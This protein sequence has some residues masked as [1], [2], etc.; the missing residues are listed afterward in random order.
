MNVGWDGD[1]GSLWGHVLATVAS[2]GLLVMA[3]RRG[4]LDAAALAVQDVGVSIFQAAM[5][6]VLSYRFRGRWRWIFA[7]G[8]VVV[9]LV[10]LVLEPGLANLGHLL[11]LFVGL[12]MFSLARSRPGDPWDP[13]VV[14]RRRF[15]DRRG[16]RAV[17]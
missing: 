12:C 6:G 7:G 13:S 1:V 11:A 16:R 15:S 10:V 2:Q 8:A 4:M 17:P 3:V 14:W 5:I 9:H